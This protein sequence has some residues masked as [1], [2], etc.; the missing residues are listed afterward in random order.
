MIPVLPKK[1]YL[2]DSFFVIPRP[3]GGHVQ[4]HLNTI[5]A[6]LTRTRRSRSLPTMQCVLFNVPHSPILE[7]VSFHRS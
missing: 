6:W 7:L 3:L 1:A 5:E 4:P 2:S